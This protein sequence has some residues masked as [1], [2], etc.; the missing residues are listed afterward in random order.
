L[1]IVPENIQPLLSPP[2]PLAGG[3]GISWGVGGSGRPKY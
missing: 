2:H 3:S 1:V